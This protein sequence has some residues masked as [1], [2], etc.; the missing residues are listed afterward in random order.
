MSERDENEANEN[1]KS[2]AE[3]LREFIAN[4]GGIDA[5]QLAKAAGLPNDPELINKLLSQFQTAMQQSAS[6][7]SGGVN[8]KLAQ[9]QARNIAH[10]GG[11]AINAKQRDLAN[12]ALNLGALWLDAATSIP[13]VNTEPKL[14]TRELWVSDALGLFQELSR[15]VAERMT[16]ALTETMQSSIPQELSKLN[17]EAGAFMKSAGAAMFAM[18]LG[19]AIGKLSTEALSGGDIGIPIFKDR[20]ALVPQNIDN[21]VSSFDIEPEQAYIYLL[22]RELSYARLFKQAKWLRDAVVSQMTNFASGIAIDTEGL[23]EIADN[24]DLN[25]PE[26]LR[27][28]LSSGAMIAPRT[29][30]QER[31]V[32]AIETL[33]ALIDGWVEAVTREATKL[34]PSSAAISEAVMRRRAEGGPAEKTFGTL[35]GLQLRPRKIREAVSLWQELGEEFSASK[36]DSLWEHPDQL[37]T[38]EDL[39][40]PESLLARM[41]G[42][43]DDLDQALRDLLDS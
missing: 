12:R 40:N 22:I 35:V 24:L 9:D 19:Q 2:F 23:Q 1:D 42:D 41:R 7:T 20:A 18:Q 33:L 10:E 16:Q 26:E 14:L 36:R 34:L 28:A 11:F 3:I 31:A 30:E 39:E 38:A 27:E 32:L 6:Q 37:P 8:W 29:E 43:G 13:A 17:A 4:S 21:F 5:E 15:P 25:N